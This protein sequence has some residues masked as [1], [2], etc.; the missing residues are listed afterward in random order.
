MIANATVTAKTGPADQITALVL[1]GITDL[2]FTPP[3]QFLRIKSGNNQI[4][5]LDMNGVTTFTVSVSGANGTY[6]IT[7]S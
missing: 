5:D 7:I 6:T 1:S 2:Q 3:S 4:T